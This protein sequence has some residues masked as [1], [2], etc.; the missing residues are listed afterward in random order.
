MRFGKKGFNQG[1]GMR[2]FSRFYTKEIHENIKKKLNKTEILN[3]NFFDLEIPTSLMFIDPPYFYRPSYSYIG[4]S[5]EEYNKFLN[6]LNT[7]K[8]DVL[9]TD[10]LHKDIDWNFQYLRQN[11]RTT[12][13]L[14]KSE[15]TGNAE[16]VYFNFKCFSDPL[17]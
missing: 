16:V 1:C 13:P 4:F 2:D 11:M 15:V 10:I 12:S 3:C 14:K 9:Y 8:N 17:F 5:Q 6:F 7:T